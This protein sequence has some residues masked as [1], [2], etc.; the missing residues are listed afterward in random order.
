MATT[1][2]TSPSV[3]S[4]LYGSVG[5]HS[6][7][8]GLGFIALSIIFL[9][10]AVADQFIVFEID[11]I[12]SFLAAILLLFRDSRAR[13][14]VRVLDA[15]ME[16]GDQT[17]GELSTFSDTGFTYLPTGDH[18]EEVVVVPAPLQKVAPPDGSRSRAP[19]EGF[20]PPGRG[21]AKIYVR[22]MGLNQITMDTLR[23]SLPGAMQENFGLADSVDIDSTGDRVK[24]TLHGAS[25][26][27]ACE[28][29]QTRPAKGTIGCTM[30]SFLAV[31]ISTATRR[32]V[33]LEPCVHDVGADTWT[34]SMILGPGAPVSN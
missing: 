21:L 30:A 27:C 15:I 22:E 8:A 1:A 14:Q 29:D 6:R 9:V 5:R 31:I 34:V 18:V 11:S 26:A 16:Y 12:V 24:I 33:S 13:V 32:P 7:Y 2:T 4:R 19:F 28:S 3:F 25:T 17:I 20:T 10:L 23:A